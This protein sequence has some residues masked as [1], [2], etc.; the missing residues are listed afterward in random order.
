MRCIQSLHLTRPAAKVPDTPQLTER[1]GQV[2]FLFVRRRQQMRVLHGDIDDVHGRMRPRGRF[3]FLSATVS[4]SGNSWSAE[5]GLRDFPDLQG[6]AA[7]EPLVR[8]GIDAIWVLGRL[9]AVF[10]TWV[11]L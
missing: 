2:S 4:L 8:R 10:G 7:V 11:D 6:V 3:S 5:C 9:K 1:A